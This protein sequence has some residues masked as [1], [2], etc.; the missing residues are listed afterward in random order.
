M[1]TLREEAAA[2]V[3]T[4]KA[5]SRYSGTDQIVLAMAFLVER[6][7]ARCDELEASQASTFKSDRRL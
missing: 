1:A 2:L 5:D 3:E 4:I 6:L 7:A